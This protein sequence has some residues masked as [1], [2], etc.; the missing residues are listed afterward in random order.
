ME[1]Y[2]SERN[3]FNFLL[4]FIASFI[5]HVLLIVFLP[6]FGGRTIIENKIEKE[7]IRTGLIS[8][9]EEKEKKYASQKTEKFNR[10]EKVKKEELKKEK[11]QVKK[12]EKKITTV[13]KETKEI[14]VKVE[15]KEK[16]LAVINNPIRKERKIDTKDLLYADRGRL[17]ENKA[18]KNIEL[19]FSLSE[20]R[21]LAEIDSSDMSIEAK[22]ILS[23]ENEVKIGEIE[24]DKIG[25]DYMDIS[26]IID[27]KKISDSQIAIKGGKNEENKLPK[28]IE[29]TE[30]IEGNG[31][32]DLVYY[33]MPIYPEKALKE[34]QSAVV[35][36]EFEVMGS[37]T[38]FKGITKKSGSIE[39]DRAVEKATREWKL[40]IT[41]DNMLVNG[42]VLVE[43]NFG[44]KT[45][46]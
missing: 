39:I 24:K 20:S 35:E 10:E 37:Q 14:P 22:E 45:K 1:Y 25:T 16:K 46:S 44:L 13:K 41:K 9:A 36:V 7:K 21:A 15:K 26:N 28:N 4:L 2:G 5:L 17:M 8:L 6:S 32:V 31:E 34:A 23:V 18:E 27:D 3:K 30:L 19:D 12:V 38:F 43:I 11:A 33:P 29:K 40:K 42:R